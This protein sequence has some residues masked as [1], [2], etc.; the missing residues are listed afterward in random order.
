MCHIT[1]WEQPSDNISSS[2]VVIDSDSYIQLAASAA[3][4][5]IKIDNQHFQVVSGVTG[6]GTPFIAV[7]NAISGG[8]ML[9][10]SSS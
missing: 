6:T 8:A 9:M 7:V 5:D 2:P 10:R 4:L 3:V 1:N